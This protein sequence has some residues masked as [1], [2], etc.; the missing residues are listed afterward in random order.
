M[1]EEQAEKELRRWYSEWL[2][3]E[4]KNKPPIEDN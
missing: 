3:R 4:R 1:T 2:G